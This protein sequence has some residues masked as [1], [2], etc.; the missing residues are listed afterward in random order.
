VA[1]F[2]PAGVVGL[3]GRGPFSREA[4]QSEATGLAVD[5]EPLA[6]SQTATQ[7]MLHVANPTNAST[8]DVMLSGATV[9]RLGLMRVEPQPLRALAGDGKLLVTVGIPDSTPDALVRMTVRR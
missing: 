7:V 8:L 4:V 9:E 3:L 2:V 1:L 5:F 6:R